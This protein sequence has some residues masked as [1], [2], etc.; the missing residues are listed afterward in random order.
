MNVAV[1]TSDARDR[2][3][4]PHTPWPDVQPPPTRVPNPTSTPAT[5]STGVEAGVAAA[6]DATTAAISP[7]PMSPAR[8][9]IRSPRAARSPSAPAEDPADARHPSGGEQ[10]HRRGEA[11]EGAAQKSAHMCACLP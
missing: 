8:N 4:M 6:G 9:A 5:I 2:R 1:A 7:A 10:V 11:D 3:E